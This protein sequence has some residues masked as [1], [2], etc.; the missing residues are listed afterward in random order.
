M[1]SINPDNLIVSIGLPV[2][3][4]EILLKKRIDSILNQTCKNFELIIS[5]NAS[6]DGT[7]KICEEYQKYDDRIQYICQKKNNGPTENFRFVLFHAKAK[8]FVWAASDDLWEPT[9]LSKNIDL[10]ESNSS[11]MGS[12]SEVDFFGKYAD[13]YNSKSSKIIKNKH[14]RPFSGSFSEKAKI[15]LLT[16]D[17]MIYAVYRTNLLKKCMPTEEHFRDGMILMLSLLKFGDFSVYDKILMHR[18]A[19]GVSSIGRIHSMKQNKA[20][21]LDILLMF[22]PLI[23]WSLNHLGI[24]FLI[25]NLNVYMRI[26]YVGYGRIILDLIRKIK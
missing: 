7:R 4:G 9:F 13:R 21:N 16:G 10:L 20:T 6:T 3:N 12:I 5:D 26:F 18:S 25:T 1:S 24:K 8:Y 11:I 17:T 23:K 2:F 19:D 22:L 15:A 14:V